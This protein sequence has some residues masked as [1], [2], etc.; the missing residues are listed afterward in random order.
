MTEVAGDSTA[1]DSSTNIS[2]N[3]SDVEKISTSSKEAMIKEREKVM[4]RRA[5]P[6]G[7]K[8]TKKQI[9]EILELRFVGQHT[10]EEIR[11]LTGA[12]LMA[13]RFINSKYKS[14]FPVVKIKRP[15]QVVFPKI[16]EGRLLELQ[17]KAKGVS[18]SF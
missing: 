11:V 16:D 2:N 10:L 6:P 15:K 13:I 14:K 8:Y 12:S 5:N 9:E 4:I 7:R 17:K 1:S 3:E 18:R